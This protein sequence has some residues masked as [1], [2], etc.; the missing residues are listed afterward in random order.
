MRLN[1]SVLALFLTAA[2]TRGGDNWPQFRGP[3]GAGISDSRGVPTRW[4]EKENIRW[5][6]AIHSMGWSSPVIWGDQVWLT[7]ARADGKEYFAIC[8]DRKSGKILH[9]LKLF[10]V[11]KPDPSP[12]YNSYASPTPVIEEGHVYVH[13]GRYG[14]A[15][16]DTKTAKVLWERRDLPCNHWRRPGS[17]PILHGKRLFLTFDGYDVQYVVA[18]DKATGKTNWKKDRD[19]KYSSDDGDIKKGFSTPSILE[20]DGK[21]QLVSPA[22]EATIAY[23]PATG[24]ELWRVIHGGMNEATIPQFGKGLVFLTT[25]HT[26]QLLA[27]RQGGRGDV[28]KKGVAWKTQRGVA[29]TRPSPLLVGDHLYFVSDNGVA[30]CVDAK[31]GKQ[32]WKERLGGAFSGSPVCVGGH[33]YFA[34]Q[35]GKTH[36]VAASPTFKRIA[37]NQL[38][39]GCMAS[40]AIAVDAL[41]LRTKTHLYC[42]SER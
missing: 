34:D 21:P 4:S 8:V 31:T 14:T 19:I 35:D 33:I 1:V 18:L 12:D 32:L 40:P 26:A 37:V 16:L 7:T 10:T 9:D 20:V 25:G 5:K 6:T 39:A 38:D 41:F 24:N 29:P 3:S 28:T 36:V 23:D 11:A 17:S 2:L 30:S 27:V 22:A 13:F 42:I 15:C